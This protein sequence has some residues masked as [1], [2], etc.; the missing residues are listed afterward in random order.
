[1]FMSTHLHVHRRWIAL[2]HLLVM[3][4][5]TLVGPAI[6]RAEARVLKDTVLAPFTFTAFYQCAE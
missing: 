1:M 2:P 4:A 3:V 5:L 6:A